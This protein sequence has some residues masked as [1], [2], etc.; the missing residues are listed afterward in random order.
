MPAR[1]AYEYS[2]IRVVPRIEREECINAGVI[3]FCKLRRYLAA[4]VHFDEARV[5]ALD[6]SADLVRIRQQLELVPLLA[7]GGP[8]AGELGALSQAERF[9]WIT[10]PRNTIIQP[11]PVHPGLCDDAEAALEALFKRLVLP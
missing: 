4:R 11:S 8:A 2:V 5:L 6:P 10:S 9:R 1:A 7:A 3:L